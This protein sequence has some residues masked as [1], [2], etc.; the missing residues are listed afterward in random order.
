MSVREIFRKKCFGVQ[1]TRKFTI[2]SAAITINAQLGVVLLDMPAL[3]ICERL[4]GGQTTVLSESKRDSVQ[5]RRESSHRILFNGGNLLG[6]S[7]YDSYP[8]N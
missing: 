8:V 5:C 1:Q 6:R 4:N 2:L 3:D 7:D